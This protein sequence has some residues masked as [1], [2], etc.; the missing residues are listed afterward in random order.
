MAYLYATKEK[1]NGHGRVKTSDGGPDEALWREKGYAPHPPKSEAATQGAAGEPT[2][3]QLEDMTVN[4]LGEYVEAN[5]I[6]VDLAAHRLKAEKVAA[7][8]QAIE[9]QSEAEE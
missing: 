2:G 9:A 6:D 3:D 8:R 7:I 4:E 1:V 5:E